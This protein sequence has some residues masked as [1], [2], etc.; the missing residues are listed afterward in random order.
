[1]RGVQQ[2]ADQHG[3]GVE[4]LFVGVQGVHPPV[5]V[6]P[7]FQ[8]VVGALEQREAD[9]LAA[10]AYTNSILPL[11]EAEAGRIRL[12]AEAAR[13]RRAALAGGDADL[14]ARRLEAYRVSP[15]VFTSDLYL[16][17]VARALR[18]ARKFI[19]DHPRAREVLTFNFEEKAYPDLF[20]LGPLPEEEPRP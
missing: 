11:A 8:S 9:L 6:A 16:G 3:L 12:E 2:G 1:M 15:V 17:T 4:I 19:L 13:V 20:D 18:G 10:R 7:A 5:A 14:F